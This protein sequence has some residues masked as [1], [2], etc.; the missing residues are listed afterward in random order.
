[1]LMSNNGNHVV[2]VEVY[3]SYPGSGEIFY[4]RQGFD[5]GLGMHYKSGVNS[6]EMNKRGSHRMIILSKCRGKDGSGVGHV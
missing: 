4:S 1:M 2:R 6:G 5:T 3:R